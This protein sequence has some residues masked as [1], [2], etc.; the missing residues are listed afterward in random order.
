MP[1]DHDG[2]CI[3]AGTRELSVKPKTSF[4][5]VCGDPET[6]K[7]LGFVVRELGV[8]KGAPCTECGTIGDVAE[9]ERRRL[10]AASLASS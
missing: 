1:G 7:N 2:S 4:C 9:F 10:A 8:L 6:Q 3:C 5:D